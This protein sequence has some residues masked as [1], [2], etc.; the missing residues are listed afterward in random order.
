MPRWQ[1]GVSIPKDS[2]DVV[3][4]KL[5][6]V[7]YLGGDTI[8]TA[9]ATGTGITVDS[10]SNANGVV[11]ARISGGNSCGQGKVVF[12]VT[13]NGGLVTENTILVNVKNR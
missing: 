6:C 5:N 12:K 1:P 9:T 4:V 13:T 10:V 11:T 2:T 8:A 7:Q 3:D